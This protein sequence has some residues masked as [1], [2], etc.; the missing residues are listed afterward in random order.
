MFLLY[1]KKFCEMKHKV[2][3]FLEKTSIL[4][5]KKCYQFFYCFP[6][7]VKIFSIAALIYNIWRDISFIKNINR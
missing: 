7:L 5:N 6:I 2:I 1:K 3:F 4:K